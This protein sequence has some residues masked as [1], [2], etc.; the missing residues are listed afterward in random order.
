MYDCLYY[1]PDRVYTTQVTKGP[2]QKSAPIISVYYIAII[3]SYPSQP[4]RAQQK[5]VHLAAHRR[6]VFGVAIGPG[7]E[8]PS[9]EDSGHLH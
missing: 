1:S 3:S 8:A 4:V 6:P 9:R 2:N 5:P 7:R